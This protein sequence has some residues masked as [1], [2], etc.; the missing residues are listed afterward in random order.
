MCPTSGTPLPMP[1][2]TP[3]QSLEFRVRFA[4]VTDG[5]AQGAGVSVR[6][7]RSGLDIVTPPVLM[8]HIGGGVYSAKIGLTGPL[9]LPPEPGYTMI[10]K[11]ETHV[12]RKFCKQVGQSSPC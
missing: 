3:V 5:S 8:T 10:L 9:T 4:G 7:I 12:A 6:F 11:G 1:T 2:L